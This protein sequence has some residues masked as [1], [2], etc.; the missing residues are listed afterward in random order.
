MGAQRIGAGRGS[1]R[2]A[3]M[4]MRKADLVLLVLALASADRVAAQESRAVEHTL[5]DLPQSL[6]FVVPPRDAKAGKAGQQARL[7][8][9]L[10]GGDGSREFLPFV[11]NGLGAQ[12]PDDCLLVLVTA[13]KWTDAQQI[14]W[15]T[16]THKV[17]GMAYTTEQYVRAVVQEMAKQ[18]TTEP[19]RRAIVAW[20]S[21]G[22]AVQAL[23][24]AADGPF[25][26]GYVA[27]SIWPRDLRDL[28]AVKGRRYVLDQSPDDRTTTFGH[29]RDAFAALTKAGAVVRLS[30][31]AGGHGWLDDPL[32]RFQAGMRWLLADEPA[33]APVWPDTKPAA[34][35]ASGKNLLANG[36]FEQGTKG[37]NT[38]DNSKRLQVAT[39]KVDKK[40]G[41]LSLHLQ[42]TGAMP[43]DL[44]TQEVELP[45][46]ANVSVSAMVKSRGAQNAWLKVWLYDDAGKPVHEQVDLLRVPADGDWQPAAKSWLRHG[47]ARAVVQIVMVGAGELWVDDVVLTV[48]T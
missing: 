32:P 10:P 40:E 34:K 16:A 3:G 6:Y 36:G 29:A 37:W 19:A 47:A 26:R 44:L 1:A 39:S 46:G 25:A 21:S 2:V 13:V 17:D 45:A 35:K 22:P 33:P 18:Y 42:K 4:R 31:Y 7:V 12:L 15:P 24:A 11:E 48:G 8:V 5:A 27:M 9:V 43:L 23:L 28:A 41:K 20:S 30:T 14:V 38:I